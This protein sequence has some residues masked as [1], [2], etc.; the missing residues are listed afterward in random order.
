MFQIDQNIVG[1]TID[2]HTLEVHSAKLSAAILVTADRTR[3]QCGF[4]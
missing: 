2:G 4:E 3:F 1:M